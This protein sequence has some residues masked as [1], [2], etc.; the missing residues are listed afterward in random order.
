MASTQELSDGSVGSASSASGDT[1]LPSFVDFAPERYEALLAAVF[2]SV[3]VVPIPYLPVDDAFED[4]FASAS[5]VLLL[6]PCDA[7]PAGHRASPL[8]SVRNGRRVRRRS[9]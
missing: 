6:D 1:A 7:A 3:A 5:R 2:P 4:G 9:E 8:A